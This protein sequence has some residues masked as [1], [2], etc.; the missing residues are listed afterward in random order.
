[1]SLHH[2]ARNSREVEIRNLYSIK[3]NELIFIGNMLAITEQI[4]LAVLNNIIPFHKSINVSYGHTAVNK[5]RL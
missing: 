5:F 3:K 4:M 1:M 2:E